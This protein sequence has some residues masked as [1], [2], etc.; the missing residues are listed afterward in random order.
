VE[1]NQD[2]GRQR[3]RLPMRR[4]S[5]NPNGETMSDTGRPAQAQAL[6]NAYK[7]GNAER[8]GILLDSLRLKGYNYQ[9]C[10][11]LV[12]DAVPELELATWDAFLEEVDESDSDD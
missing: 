3:I 11:Q 2:Y 6:V 4:A 5:I 9:R 12:K 7:T 1:N 8:A 10:F